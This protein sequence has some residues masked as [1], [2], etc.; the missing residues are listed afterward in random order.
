MTR[1][2]LYLLLLLFLNVLFAFASEKDVIVNYT[3]D[4]PDGTK[5]EIP[6]RFDLV[7]V[8]TKVLSDDDILDFEAQEYSKPDYMDTRLVLGRHN[9]A[10]V[11]AE[12]PCSDLCPAYTVRIIRYDV[13][14]DQCD[15]VNGRI[16]KVLVPIGIAA[17]RIKFCVPAVLD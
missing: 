10:N 7:K 17:A 13:P 9:G 5:S 16:R 8:D 14:L 2:G 12:H 6:M 3:I 4:Y 11:V 15:D 1:R